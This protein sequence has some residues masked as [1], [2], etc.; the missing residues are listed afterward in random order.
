MFR[1]NTPRDALTRPLTPTRAETN[2]PSTGNQFRSL[3]PGQ[4]R[5]RTVT[6]PSCRHGQVASG[7][8]QT[9]DELKALFAE[10]P[11]SG[12]PSGIAAEVALSVRPA[13]LAPLGVQ[14]LGV[15][16]AVL[17]DGSGELSMIPLYS[18]GSRSRCERVTLRTSRRTPGPV[19]SAARCEQFRAAQQR[20]G[21]GHL[22]R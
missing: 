18:R 20:T 6:V 11:C 14:V 10:V 15:A 8:E 2:V 21:V 19:V 3:R 13:H 5:R 16:L 17:E 1:H 9:A 12:R 7:G 4:V 22:G